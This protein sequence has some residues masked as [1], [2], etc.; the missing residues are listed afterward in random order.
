MLSRE[1][2]LSLVKEHI[3]NENLVK[4]CLATEAIMRKMADRFNEDPD[5][6]GVTGLLH[7]LDFEYTH[8]DPA[9]HALKTIELLD[10]Y[11]LPEDVKHA[12][13]SHNEEGNGTKRESV[14]DYAITCSECITG[15]IVAT[16]LVYPD[17]KVS[18][19]KV[20]SVKKRM[21]EK[22]FARSVNREAILL[23][24]KINIPLEEFIGLSIEAMSGISEDL[25]L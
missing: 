11:N 15:L 18:S 25:G 10:E 22:A 6:W 7:D 23:C 16:A 13:L 24:E 20:K 1:S 2:A 5:K 14:F 9:N 19:V 17:K 3:K 4:H 21:K 12:I 8:N